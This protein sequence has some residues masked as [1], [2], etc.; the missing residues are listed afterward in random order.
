VADGE[1]VADIERDRDPR[2]TMALDCADHEL[3]VGDRGGPENDPCGAGGK[4]LVDRRL[5]AEAAG[6]LDLDAVAGG[7]RKPGS[8]DD[9]GDHVRL[10]APTGDRA[11]EVD[12]VDP[13]RPELGE[14]S[15]NAGRSAVVD[16]LS[17]E[18]P[19]TEPDDA[20]RSQV[21]GRVQIER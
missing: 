19:L 21:D 1:S 7:G 14:P 9:G 8:V 13:R 12:D 3:G 6:D 20:T 4:C 11:V 16:L 17:G 18:V 15:G 2:G 5:V 10:A